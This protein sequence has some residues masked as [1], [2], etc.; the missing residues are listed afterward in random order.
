MDFLFLRTNPSCTLM[1]ISNANLFCC[2][3][4]I[5]SLLIKCNLVI[6]HR[7]TDIFHFSRSHSSFNPPPLNL[8]PLGGPVLLLKDT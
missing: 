2:Y 8:S 3:N 7:K 5:S 6:K 4:I 1:L